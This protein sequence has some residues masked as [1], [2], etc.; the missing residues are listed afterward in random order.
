RDVDTV[1][2]GELVLS[3]EAVWAAAPSL[4]VRQQGVADDSEAD[5]VLVVRLGSVV[6]LARVVVVHVA[7]VIGFTQEAGLSGREATDHLHVAGMAVTLLRP[8]QEQFRPHVPELAVF[9]LLGRREHLRR[10][11]DW[12]GPG[13]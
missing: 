1:R 11:S 4:K 9:R 12:Y 2:V 5:E 13:R 10:P 6:R 8:R 7:A 3:V